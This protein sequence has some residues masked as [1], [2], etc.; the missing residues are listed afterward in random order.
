MKLEILDQDFPRTWNGLIKEKGRIYSLKLIK[1]KT[2][3]QSEKPKASTPKEK[4]TT[5]TSS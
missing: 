4:H 2:L 5:L 1:E 3:E